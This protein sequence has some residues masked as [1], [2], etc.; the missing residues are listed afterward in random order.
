MKR[1]RLTHDTIVDAAAEVA[2]ARGLERLSMRAVASELGVEAM[3]LYHHVSN[4]ESLLDA[5][6][7]W[8]YARITLPPFDAPWQDAQRIRAL[9][10]RA[11]LA[12]NPWALTLIES[13]T[14]PG[15]HLLRHH[16]AVIGSFRCNGFT[17]QQAAHAML[18]IDAYI[19]GF[20]LNET[21]LPFE[22]GAEAD[23]LTQDMKLP[24]T[25]FPYLAEFVDTLIRDK[26]YNF[27]EQFTAGLD[28][29][30]HGL[31]P[32]DATSIHGSQEPLKSS[33]TQ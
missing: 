32:T 2:R 8:V 12:Q 5:L 18:V 11:I 19:Y 27:S 28:L 13:R 1:A 3:S 23:Q 21:Q 6:V 26:G 24:A 9:S 4:K 15:P 17:V 10:A 16:N 20:V 14:T 30:L 29:I 31:S 33:E 7:E 22:G 25:D